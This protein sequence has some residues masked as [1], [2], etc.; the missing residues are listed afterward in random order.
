[1]KKG[2][3]Y[4]DP[5]KSGLVFERN[6]D[7]RMLLEQRPG[8]TFEDDYICIGGER[9]GLLCGKH[10]LY[11][12]FLA[13]QGV[14]DRQI[15]RARLLPD[16]AIAAFNSR[17]L[18]IL[19]KKFQEVPGSVDEKLATCDFKLKQ[20]R[21]LVSSIGYS[22]QFAY[23]LCDWF[24]DKRYQDYLEYIKSVQCSYFFREVPFDLFKL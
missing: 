14:D 6:T 11:S 19:E 7:L 8:I 22:V 5:T 1:M 2:E 16:E 10:K 17:V 21:K 4:S 3:T 15:L 13:S 9:R 18:T 23:V 20:Y 12:G 24:R